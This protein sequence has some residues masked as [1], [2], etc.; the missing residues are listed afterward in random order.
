MN[1]EK[2]D[3]TVIGLGKSGFSAARLLKKHQANVKVTDVGD[4]S[5]VKERA[6]K[7]RE[8]EIE[9]EV[10]KHTGE[11]LKGQELIVASP[12]VS[13]ESFP[14]QYAEKNNI[15][16]IG[17][18]ELGFRYCKTPIIGISGTNGKTTVATMLDSILGKVGINSILC[19]NVGTPF[20][21]IVMEKEK[22]TFLVLEISSFQLERIKKFRPF[23]GVLLGVT[24]DHLDRHKDEVSY[25]TAKYNLFLN[26]SNDDWAIV[27]N[28]DINFIEKKDKFVYL[29]NRG[30]D[31]V[32]CYFHNNSDKR[33]NDILRSKKIDVNRK[34]VLLVLS[35]LNQKVDNYV[36]D[37]LKFGNL[38]HRLEF[39][40]K[41]GGV[42]FINDSK[43]TNISSTV[44]ALEKY[45]EVV[46]IAG[47]RNKNL[48]FNLIPDWFK[49]KVKYVIVMGE[50]AD[51]IKKGFRNISPVRKVKNMKEAV[52][53]S[54]KLS[55]T[56]DNVI[57]SPMCSSFDMFYDYKNRG[58][59]F[60][61]EV[62]KLK[63]RK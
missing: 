1:L 7:L 55:K 9:V 45:D 43:S 11:M 49:E 59:V 2:K 57:L 8:L 14:L 23:I 51:E 27:V 5:E 3:V 35:L 36:N 15:P 50:S 28:P 48:D 25:K 63:N 53:Y 18:I 42:S 31:S 37:V 40:S 33:I 26:Q 22:P 56:G 61:Q 34:I 10:G 16:V 41:I 19:G 60:K 39:I 29:N 38:P 6:R 46:L 54:Y 30:I 58:N 12:G 4:S 21:E 62:E 13:N 17:E 32:S 24:R 44:W 20:T 47:G 52:R